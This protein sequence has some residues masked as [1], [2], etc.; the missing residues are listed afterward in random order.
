MRQE[1]FVLKM[2]MQTSFLP[3]PTSLDKEAGPIHFGPGVI[4]PRRERLGAKSR[5]EMS[6][7]M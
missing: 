4:A 1:G 6:G 3:I 7:A 2:L 5:T